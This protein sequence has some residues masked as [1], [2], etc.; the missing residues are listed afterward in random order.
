MAKLTRN[1]WPNIDGVDRG[2]ACSSGTVIGGV[3]AGKMGESRVLGKGDRGWRLRVREGIG[4]KE[5]RAGKHT[6]RA[7]EEQ[8]TC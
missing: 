7:L 2:Q 8:R 3:D 6:R 1:Q 4:G 5:R